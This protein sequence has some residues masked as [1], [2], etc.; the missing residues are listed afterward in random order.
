[1]N[2]NQNIKTEYDKQKREIR[3]R[4]NK[5]F[6]NQFVDEEEKPEPQ[7][8]PEKPKPILIKCLITSISY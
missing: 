8:E 6:P 7:P 1:M 2:Y 4:L 3:K 5:Q